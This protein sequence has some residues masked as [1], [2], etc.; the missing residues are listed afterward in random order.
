M[1]FV[2][3]RFIKQNITMS[4]LL[5]MLCHYNVSKFYFYLMSFD[6]K[7]IIIDITFNKP[8][9]KMHHLLHFLDYHCKLC[10]YWLKPLQL[11]RT[12]TS[13]GIIVIYQ[14]VLW[15]YILLFCCI[16][17][18]VSHSILWCKLFTIFEIWLCFKMKNICIYYFDCLLTME[19]DKLTLWTLGR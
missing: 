15:K 10:V 16:R 7:V 17:R 18:I 13:I 5:F 14:F 11:H 1:K 9:G 12:M 8:S 3:I 2:N 4:W 19:Y 6:L